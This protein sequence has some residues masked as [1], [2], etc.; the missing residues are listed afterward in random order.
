MISSGIKLS[1]IMLSYN[2]AAYVEAALQSV[3]NQ[4]T[5]FA[6]EILVGDD[7][8]VDGTPGVIERY[9]RQYPGRITPVLRAQNIGAT[10]NLFDLMTRARGD[11]LAY[12]ECDDYWTDP[13]K[14]QRQF[15]FL[16]SNPEYIGCTHKIA[17]VDNDGKRIL[18]EISWISKKENYTLADFKGIFLPGQVNSLVH[19]NIF[20]ES[21][22]RYQ[23]LITLHPVIADRSL[24]L[25]LASKGAIRQL[26][27]E[28]GCYRSPAPERGS[29][30]A[31]LYDA[32]PQRSWDDYVYTKQLEAYAH[33]TLKAKASFGYHKQNLLF[34]AV[35]NWFR[36][37]RKENLSIVIRMLRSEKSVLY[38]FSIFTVFVRKIIA[39][40]KRG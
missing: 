39:K 35:Y 19:R 18:N 31:V 13:L 28:M 1:V 4:K 27:Q 38:F 3:L 8:S 26:P 17:V 34:E 37:P 21:G 25:L 15:D 32:N 40:L 7:A 6:F 23:E 16:E 2:H 11:Y 24:C 22:T 5:S 14:L 29:A 36:R 30:T 10:R 9:A 20:R 33:Q 12:L